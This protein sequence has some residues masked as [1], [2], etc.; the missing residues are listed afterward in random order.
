MKIF[1]IRL[2]R[3]RQVRIRPDCNSASKPSQLRCGQHTQSTDSTTS[4]HLTTVVCPAPS[5][6]QACTLD[7]TFLYQT[8]ISY[9][10]DSCR[11]IN[12]SVSISIFCHVVWQSW[13]TNMAEYGNGRELLKQECGRYLVNMQVCKICTLHWLLFC[14]GPLNRFPRVLGP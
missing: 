2:K 14:F 6:Q 3:Y 1:L 5:T 11:F 9:L 13:P 8:Y 4:K 7:G 12:C 10:S